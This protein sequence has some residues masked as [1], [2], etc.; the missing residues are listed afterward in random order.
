[1]SDS[2]EAHAHSDPQRALALVAQHEQQFAQGA[3]VQEREV[4]AIEALLAAGERSE[5]EHRAAAFFTRFPESA[6]FRRLRALL[7][8]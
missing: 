1:M 6:H 2:C 5:S 8:D 3:L 4:I 7:G